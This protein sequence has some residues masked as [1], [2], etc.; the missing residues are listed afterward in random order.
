MLWQSLQHMLKQARHGALV[1]E[2][3]LD[4]L[5]VIKE[6]TTSMLTITADLDNIPNRF[7][8]ANR[9][10]LLHNTTECKRLVTT[11]QFTG[12]IVALQ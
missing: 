9:Y 7:I 11:N 8:I 6:T 5:M 12:T 3:G 4:S 10:T 2:T 1:S